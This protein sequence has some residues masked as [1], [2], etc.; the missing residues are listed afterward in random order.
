[1]ERNKVS[2]HFI[3]LGMTHDMQRSV[4]EW[5]AA[6]ADPETG[7]VPSFSEGCRQ[8]IAKGLADE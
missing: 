6:N 5:C 2:E 4:N 1:M 7:K 3:R 8:L